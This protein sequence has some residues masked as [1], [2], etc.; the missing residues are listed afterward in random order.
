MNNQK[1]GTSR[2]VVL[3][4]GYTALILGFLL[5]G[6]YPILRDVRS[7]R[8]EI[9]RLR[10][11][12]V[13]RNGKK[14]EL[15]AISKNV[16]ELS[17]ETKALDRLL[18]AN[19]DLGGFLRMMTEKFEASG[20]REPMFRNLPSTPLGRSEK[21]PIEVKCRGTYEQFHNFLVGL[22]SL[23]RLCSVGRMTISAD[24]DMNGGIEAQLTIYIYNS[25]PA[26][27]GSAAV[28]RP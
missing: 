22:E 11:E 10:E 2:K 27:K 17:L 19:Q 8:A 24:S 5:A 4:G 7:A 23:P 20:M 16:V 26:T 1:E 13:S 18:P 9:G 25:K 12:I 3:R 15:E 21:L 28:T 14:T 6:A